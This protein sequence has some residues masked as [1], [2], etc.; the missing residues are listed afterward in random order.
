MAA[1][2][3]QLR[4]LF[5]G[6]RTEGAGARRETAAVALGVFIGCLPLYGLHLAICWI[7]GFVL[8]L[9]RLK[10]YFAANVSNPF[11][12]PWL[13][14]VEVQVGAWMRRGSFHPVTRESIASAGLA[15]LGVDA[16]V[17]SLFVGAALAAFAAWGTYSL[18]GASGEDRPF[19]ELVR[20][21]SDRYVG[22]SI[23][24]WEFAR[25][26]LR[27]DPIYRATLSPDLLP[28]GG[29]LVD[30]GCG[31]G[32][33]LALLVEARNAVD[34]GTWPSQWPLPPRFD[35]LIGIE[36]RKRVA[37]IA[38]AALAAD[39]EI[40]DADVRALPLGPARV[41]LLFD[42]LQLLPRTDQDALLANMAARLDS[43]GVLLVREADASAGWRFATVRLN[44]RLK[45]L[46][47]GTWRQSFHA[48]TD[49]EWRA[50]FERHGFRIDSRP[51][52]KAPFANMMFRL[53]V[54][55]AAPA[56]RN[57]SSQPA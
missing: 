50:C 46:M 7:V 17:G 54:G 42:V 15:V 13:V 16:L 12:A 47:S 19:A 31:Q 27:M 48:R 8:G 34:D 20:R 57:Q 45:L 4:R 32:L 3:V 28:S 33:S 5:Q 26:K 40:V 18:V 49:A 38:R 1:V 2:S 51:M 43:D 14:F 37:K 52:G 21:A 10:M 30:V 35:R 11:V 53:T 44:S 41:V 24:A 23:T 56:P 55:P 6:L 22:T 39:A 29:T 36:L 9:N 25:G